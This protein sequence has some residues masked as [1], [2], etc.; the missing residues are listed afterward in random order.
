[1]IRP[2][3]VRCPATIITM[4]RYAVGGAKMASP[5]SKRHSISPVGGLAIF[6][7]LLH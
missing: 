1:M 5:V 4:P 7:N 3:W 6:L 2:V